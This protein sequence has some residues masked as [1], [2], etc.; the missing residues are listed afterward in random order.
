[1][2]AVM[3]QAKEPARRAEV[4]YR[5]FELRDTDAL[6]EIVAR[7]VP[8]LPNYRGIHVDRERVAFLLMN[9]WNNATYLIGVLEAAGEIV[10]AVVGWCTPTIFSFE[11]VSLDNFLWIDPRYR[12]LRS[13][14]ELIRAYKYWALARG[15][16]IVGASF[17]GGLKPELMDLLL[18]RHGFV[19]IGALYHLR[20]TH[21]IGEPK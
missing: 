5:R 9:N 2:S 7:E 16:V 20:V 10:G 15:A 11:N 19:P 12:S 8:Q 17:T 4:T 13:V 6:V 3:V 14:G 21:T 18:K 1:M